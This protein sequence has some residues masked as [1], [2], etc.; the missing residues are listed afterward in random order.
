[1]KVTQVLI[2]HD[3]KFV[4]DLCDRIVVLDFG[5]QRS[6]GPPARVLAEPEVIAAYIGAKE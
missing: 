3:V 1:M 4:S 2:E 6:E 5:H